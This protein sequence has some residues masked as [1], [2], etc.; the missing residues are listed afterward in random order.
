[1]AGAA[2]GSN[3]WAVTAERSV[4]GGALIA[5][6]P[7]LPTAMPGIWHQNALELGD[8][9]CRGAALPGI[10]GITMGQNNDVAW[11]FT[12]VMA[13]VEDL[14]VERIEGDRYEFEGE[15]HDLER[16]RPRRSRSRADRRPEI[17][18]RS[19][20]TDHGPIVNDVIGA[21][22]SQPLA[23]RW[24]GDGLPRRSAA[25]TWRSSSRPRE[26]SWSSCSAT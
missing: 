24:I 26:P 25:P 11:T 12:N 14:F 5:G 4:T 20:A 22:D 19:A 13:D 15:W 16:G 9:F 1:M 7:H 2:G 10:P 8:R 21:D 17:A 18:R 3:N 23:L 6:D